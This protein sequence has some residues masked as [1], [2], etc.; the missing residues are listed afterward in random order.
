MNPEGGY[1]I[2]GLCYVAVSTVDDVNEVH[3]A[4]LTLYQT[5]LSFNNHREEGIEKKH[6]E[7]RS[8]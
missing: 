6:F 7:K 2:P 8:C 1:H 3:R 5:I 4:S